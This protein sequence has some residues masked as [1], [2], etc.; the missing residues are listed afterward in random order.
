V[1]ADVENQVLEVWV[2]YDSPKD[3]P[4]KVVVRKWLAG[5]DFYAPTAEHQVFPDVEA[6]RAWIRSTKAGLARLPRHPHDEAVVLET[7]L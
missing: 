5:A 4:G 7:W 6:A 1:S 2:V 3:F